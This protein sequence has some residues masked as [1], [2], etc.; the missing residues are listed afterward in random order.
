MPQIVRLMRVS[1]LLKPVGK[2][3]ICFRHQDLKETTAVNYNADQHGI[4]AFGAE[5]PMHQNFREIEREKFAIR[6]QTCEWTLRA[7][8]A[9][10]AKVD[11]NI[12]MHGDRDHLAQG[13]IFMFNHFARFE[14]F[15][16]QYLI[17]LETGVFCRSIASG[18]FFVEDNKFSRYLRALGGVPNDYERLL[19]FLAEEILRGGKVVIFPEGGMVKD[20]R[21]L[22]AERPHP[23]RPDY[24]IYSRS[25]DQRRA[26]HTGAAL[27]ALC[28]DGFKTGLSMLLDKGKHDEL[29][30]WAT[31]ID[32]TPEILKA[33]L[34]KP[35][36]M[37]PAN[38]TF[39]P[40]RVDQNLLARGADLFAGGLSPKMA[41]ELIIEGNLL[42]KRT[43]MDIRLGDPVD[44]R[45]QF[46]WIDR[47]LLAHRVET[48]TCIDDLFRPAKT[49]EK[50]PDRITQ[51]AIT[52]HIS[53][54]RDHCM[55]V[56]YSNLTLNVSH[57]AS[58]L[59]M[60]WLA[61]GVTEVDIAHF[62]RTLY[63]AIKNVQQAEGVHLHRGMR[64]PAD[65]IGIF[66]LKCPQ[67]R[68]YID[69]AVQLGLIERA[70]G[71]YCFLPKLQ[72]EA[73]FDQIRMDNPVMVYANEMAPINAAWTALEKARDE[74]DH[75]TLRDFA[76]RRF[77]DEIRAWQWNRAKYQKPKYA[78][79]NDQETAT[80]DSRPYLLLPNGN[81][82]FTTG[83]LVVHGFLASPA[84]L[85]NL[86]DRL[87][88]RDYAV[89]GVRLAGHGTSPHELQKR[90]WGDWLASV[91][92]GYEILSAFCDNIIIVGFSTGGALSTILAADRPEKLTGLV[93][94]STP[95][96]FR[97]RN[98]MFVPLLYG[99]NKLM[100]WVPSAQEMLS[101]RLNESEHPDINYRNIPIGGLHNLRQAVAE[102]QNRLPDIACP[103]LILQGDGDQVVDPASATLIKRHATG[104][105]K[106]D[107]QMLASDRHG[108]LNEDIDNAVNRV[109]DFISKTAPADSTLT[110]AIP[111][112]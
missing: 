65:Y 92:R 3:H 95:L 102:M 94:A 11:I 60:M 98:L 15:I 6:N 21:V 34:A 67:I 31:A 7:M 13:D 8:T 88:A 42:F 64:N 45:H 36:L 68:E 17:A 40:L 22:A 77:D 18:E 38:I 76:K 66:D 97:N 30:R 110:A 25:A 23:K 104:C 46:N 89:M 27:L 48:A 78:S 62:D 73:T 28:I 50:I 20:R 33:A 4:H 59:I 47:R 84:E 100:G 57:L 44:P 71:K 29:D 69:A 106:L 53:P 32:T 43:D 16:P 87:A 105:S 112:Q 19:P 111:A 91:R 1:G 35:T 51:Y 61:D 86:G 85:R 14:T 49:L 52:R 74:V 101:F 99:A 55:A 96:K 72:E 37:F 79:I 2:T 39:H 83:V 58:R 81:E 26:H 12:K 75:L 70:D 82:H 103:I 9:L 108:I 109:I 93:V 54:L 41:E 80:A 63:L 5:T 90:T 56:M 107:I 10:R 24:S